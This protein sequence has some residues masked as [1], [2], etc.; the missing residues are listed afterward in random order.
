LCLEKGIAIKGKDGLAMKAAYE[1]EQ[2]GGYLTNPSELSSG[3]QP[4]FS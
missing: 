2:L 4:Q 3:D 1:V